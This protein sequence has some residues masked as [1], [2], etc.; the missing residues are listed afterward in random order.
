VGTPAERLDRAARLSPRGAPARLEI[1]ADL[2]DALLY[3]GHADAAG[4]AVAELLAE[5][6]PD[7]GGTLAERARLQQVLLRFLVD[8][9]AIP[10]E[11]L[12]ARTDRALEAFAAAGDERDLATA[13]WARS[14]VAWLEGDA[15]A[16]Q[17]HAELGLELARRSGNRRALTDAAASLANALMRGPVRLDEA[18]ARLQALVAEL[19]GDRLSQAALRLDL[20]VI[21]SLRGFPKEARAEADRAQEVFRDLGQRRW[22]ARCSDILA[23]LAM[24]EE[25]APRAAELGR[26]VHAFFLEQGDAANALP[27]AMS[28]AAAL[29]EAGRTD[30]ADALAADVEREAPVDDLE[31][32]VEWRL[33][34]A[35]AAAHRGEADRA[36]ALAQEAIDLADGTDFLLMQADARANFAEVL[37]ALGRDAEAGALRREAAERYVRKGAAARAERME[38]ELTSGA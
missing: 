26:S 4:V 18:E 9:G 33:V 22:L 30:E 31:T 12:R 14:L 5:L 28:L 38:R 3:A 15:A 19:E 8:P 29:L 11:D 25:D 13:H 21:R 37:R 10:A 7:G 34:R 35:R 20:S 24:E 1:L 16:M 36:S 32:Q 27:A 17:T 2:H 6:D 23:D